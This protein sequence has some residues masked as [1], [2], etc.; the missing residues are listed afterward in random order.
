MKSIVQQEQEVRALQR[1]LN[2]PQAPVIP[3]SLMKPDMSPFNTLLSS[4]TRQTRIVTETDLKTKTDSLYMYN[5]ENPIH[6]SRNHTEQS[7]HDFH[8]TLGREDTPLTVPSSARVPGGV[9]NT[10]H[11]HHTDFG[12]R[13]LGR[14][15]TPLTAS[16]SAQVPGG[17]NDTDHHHYP[18]EELFFRSSRLNDSHSW[19]PRKTTIGSHWDESYNTKTRDHL[20]ESCTGLGGASVL[21][22]V[23]EAQL[24]IEVRRPRFDSQAHR[25]G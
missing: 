10:D 22:K 14:D 25:Q 7:Y 18:G 16:H 23:R 21:D 20:T 19:N 15:G 11:H 24:V 4:S 6:N 3:T 8:R 13:T 9:N 17:V 1:A 5:M 2:L 12:S